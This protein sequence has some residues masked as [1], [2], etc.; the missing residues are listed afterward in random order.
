MYWYFFCSLKTGIVIRV[1][2]N[3]T[4]VPLV[5]YEQYDSTC[6]DCNTC[7]YSC[8]SVVMLRVVVSQHYR[9]GEQCTTIT[10]RQPWCV[11]LL[12]LLTSKMAEVLRGYKYNSKLSY[13]C[14]LKC[15]SNITKLLIWTMNTM[16]IYG[17]KVW[18]DV[19]Y[20]LRKNIVNGLQL[21]NHS[22]QMN[23]WCLRPR[24]WTCK[25]ILGPGQPGS[26][27]STFWKNSH[28]VNNR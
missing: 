23:E 9:T 14:G 16:T 24:F 3:K 8:I 26:F 27:T 12:L 13:I 6:N 5:W 20:S 25:A 2:E 7:T 11:I 22:H 18:V 1:Y 19:V 4:T 21:W 15:Q 28:T 10:V 17:L